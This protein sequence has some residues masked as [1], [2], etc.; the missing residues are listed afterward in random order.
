MPMKKQRGFTLLEVVIASAILLA[1]CIMVFM[2]LFSS[3]NE[4]ATQ[5]TKVSMDAKVLAILNTIAEDIRN[6]GGTYSN[7]NTAGADTPLLSTAS[8]IPVTDFFYNP[9]A[10][11]AL[12][13]RYWL[14]MGQYSGFSAV[15]QANGSPGAATYTDSVSYYWQPA[16]G[17]IPDN[18]KD[19]N[20]DGLI[21]E[22]DIIQVRTVAG[23][24]TT[25]KIGRNVSPRGL[26]F[27][28]VQGANP[29]A[30]IKVMVQL[31]G[32][33][34][35]GKLMYAQSETTAGPRSH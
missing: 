31:M 32:L 30:S 17:E 13:R 4:G 8:G 25:S 10:T 35:K 5:Q 28:M 2:L 11:P 15:K 24:V 33:D 18:G 12:Q 3:S 7:L 27:E 16:F 22:G 29:P 20:G 34:S 26:A 6:S 9:L 14:T 21:D 23:V 19:D 1:V